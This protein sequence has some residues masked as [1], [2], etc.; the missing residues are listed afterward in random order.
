MSHR[1]KKIILAAVLVAC[2]AA[3][4]SLIPDTSFTF[5]SVKGNRQALK[6]IVF[7]NYLL[8]VILFITAYGATAFLIPG[9]LLLS[10]L[11][12]F[13]FGVL[14]GTIYINIAAVA[15]AALGFLMARYLIGTWLQQRY[16][17]SLE[18]FNREV[19]KQG[20][21]YLLT[22]RIVPLL[23]FFLVNFLA[24]LTPIPLK[25]FLWTTSLGI[26]PGSLLFTYAGKQL[27]SIESPD[28]IMTPKIIVFLILSG[29]L[30]LIQAVYSHLRRA[31]E[32]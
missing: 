26:V 24:G 25:T 14:M 11:G 32:E 4:L 7:R 12:G 17:D 27:G 28:E 22:L 18:K 30:P 20:H 10:L 23:P 1:M 9:A 21:S 19:K 2:G 16:A 8:S 29:S 5:E 6:A 3:A 13:L 15:G 31:D